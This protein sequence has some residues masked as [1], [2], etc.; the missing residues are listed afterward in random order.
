MTE[1]IQN[2]K[3]YVPL[4]PVV[5]NVLRA[6]AD[7]EKHGYSIMCEVEANTRGKV[8]MGPGA[9]YGSIKRLLQADLIE[10]GIE[11]IDPQMDDQHRKYYHLTASGRHVLSVEA[12][13][14]AARVRTAQSTKILS[15]EF[16]QS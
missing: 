4:T 5:F 1:T 3:A 10:D 16:S 7:G 14:L 9:L 8:L 15:P 6:L 11:R 13:R 2:P 12:E